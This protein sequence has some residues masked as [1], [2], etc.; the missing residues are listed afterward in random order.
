MDDIARIQALV[1][2]LDALRRRLDD[3]C[4]HLGDQARTLRAW[5]GPAHEIWVTRMSA[6]ATRGDTL[7]DQLAQHQWDLAEAMDHLHL[8][9]DRERDTG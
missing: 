7:G 9:L 8:R 4:G 2:A 3:T 1:D 6:L 5:S